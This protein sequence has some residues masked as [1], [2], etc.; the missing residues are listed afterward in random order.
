M[1]LEWMVW[2]CLHTAV[3]A[4]QSASAETCRCYRTPA[5]YYALHWSELLKY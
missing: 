1:E 4:P 2:E 5:D 3:H